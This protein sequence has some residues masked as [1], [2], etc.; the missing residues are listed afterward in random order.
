[1]RDDDTVRIDLPDPGVGAGR[2]LATLASEERAWVLQ[3][4]ERV[5]LVGPNGAGKTTLLRRLVAAGS[6]ASRVASAGRI[7]LSGPA[8]TPGDRFALL[9][10][11]RRAEPAHEQAPASDGADAWAAAHAA[12]SSFMTTASMSSG[13]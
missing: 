11:P 8:E 6:G 10:P 2:R 7:D 13:W 9:L 1:M 3:G 4:P 5:A 12:R